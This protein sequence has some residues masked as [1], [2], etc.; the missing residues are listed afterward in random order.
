MAA[1]LDDFR[2]L[3]ITKGAK[4]T[5]KK[6]ANQ[7]KGQSAQIAATVEAFRKGTSPIPS[8]ELFGVMEA[9]FAAR[10]SLQT[11]APVEIGVAVE[12]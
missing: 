12:A 7:D 1:A 3:E 9:V 8:A 5:R 10:Q 2:T 6:A 4:K 11:G